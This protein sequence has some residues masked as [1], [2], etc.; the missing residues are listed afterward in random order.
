AALASLTYLSTSNYSGPDTLNLAVD[1]LDHNDLGLNG[2]DARTVPIVVLPPL[3]SPP[4]VSI[5]AP[6]DASQ[7]QSGDTITVEA[8]ATDSDGQVTNVT[9]F[10][11]SLELA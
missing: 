4:F 6:A 3:S 1:D 9:L 10:V 8:T 5:V 2:Q 11:D 7:Y